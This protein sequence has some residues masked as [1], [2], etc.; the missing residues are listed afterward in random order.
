MC[1]PM[2]AHWV[3]R[4]LGS[5]T[6]T[7]QEGVLAEHPRTSRETNGTLKLGSTEFSISP[8]EFIHGIEPDAGSR[9]CP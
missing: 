6:L 2:T 3:R 9:L 5:G 8:S 1:F 7:D 4:S